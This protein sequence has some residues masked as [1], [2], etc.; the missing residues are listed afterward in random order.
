M[1]TAIEE[2]VGERSYMVQMTWHDTVSMFNNRRS[3]L[4]TQSL[5]SET[6]TRRSLH[7]LEEIKDSSGMQLISYPN[8][9]LNS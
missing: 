6:E 9:Q 2:A 5:A 8:S 4:A 7:H 3:E 1:T